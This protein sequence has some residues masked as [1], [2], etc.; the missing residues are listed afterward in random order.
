MQIPKEFYD[1]IRQVA[2]WKGDTLN[3]WGH[4]E[5]KFGSKMQYFIEP[6]AFS[7]QATIKLFDFVDGLMPLLDFDE[8]L[9]TYPETKKALKEDTKHKRELALF[10]QYNLGY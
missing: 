2:H 3:K 10:K 5:Q 6:F 1:N 7:Q 4:F 8:Y 9:T